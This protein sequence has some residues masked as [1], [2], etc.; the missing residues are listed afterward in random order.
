MGAS[1]DEFQLTFGGGTLQL[2][3]GIATSRNHQVTNGNNAII[4]ANGFTLTDNGTIS[5]VS[6]TGGLTKI[7]SGTLVLANSIRIEKLG[8]ALALQNI[9]LPW[10]YNKPRSAFFTPAASPRAGTRAFPSLDPPRQP[11]SFSRR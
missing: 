10:P 3:T 9:Q 4:D 2:L 7:G 5:T 6:G 11:V 1:G 8:Q